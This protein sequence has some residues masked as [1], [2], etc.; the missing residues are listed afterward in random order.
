MRRFPRLIHGLFR[1]L[2]KPW[3]FPVYGGFH[4]S[5]CPKPCF[6]RR[7][8]WHLDIHRSV[9]SRDT[10][11]RDANRTL[12]RKS[13]EMWV[14]CLTAVEKGCGRCR[15]SSLAFDRLSKIASAYVCTESLWSVQKALGN[16]DTTTCWRGG[17]SL[18]A[19]QNWFYWHFQ[20]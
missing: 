8:L 14:D 10:W 2:R 5:K 17:F 16:K 19:G 18:S 1:P 11:L 6:G 20:Q 9:T 7:K 3:E 13:F 15:A 12:I 4:R